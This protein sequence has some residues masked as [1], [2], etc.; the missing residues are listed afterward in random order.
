MIAAAAAALAL[1]LLLTSHHGHA[2]RAAA[3][4]PRSRPYLSFS[5]QQLTAA[6]TIRSHEPLTSIPRSFL[7]LSTEYWTLPV[8]ERHIA[9][10]MRVLSLIHV[11]GDGRFVLRIGGDSS[12]R[13][14]YDPRIR[15]LPRWAFELTPAFIARTA[16]IV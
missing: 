3:T 16:R 4:A 15:K 8:D 10:Y 7:G 12:D 1:V 5:P 6:V 14:F 2:R 11:P 9:L 13:T